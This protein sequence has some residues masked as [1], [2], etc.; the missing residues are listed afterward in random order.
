MTIAKKE[1]AHQLWCDQIQSELNWILYPKNVRNGKSAFM[2]TKDSI[3][4][5]A[6]CAISAVVNFENL[7]LRIVVDEMI[8]RLDDVKKLHDATKGIKTKFYQLDKIRH[9]R[10]MLAEQKATLDAYQAAVLILVNT[11][12]PSG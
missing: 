11:K 4:T 1:T 8:V 10:I 5:R 7:R 12:P 9:K 6:D 2:T 3:R